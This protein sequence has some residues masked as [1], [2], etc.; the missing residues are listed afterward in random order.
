MGVLNSTYKSTY[1]DEVSVHFGL[2]IPGYRVS[3]S[4]LEVVPN[5]ETFRMTLRAVRLWA[6]RMHTNTYRTLNCHS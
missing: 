2:L 3:R 5:K 6:Q 1:V 4:I